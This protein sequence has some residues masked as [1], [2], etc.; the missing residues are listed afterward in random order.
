MNV[1]IKLHI[2]KY[3]PF[4]VAGAA[5]RTMTKEIHISRPIITHRT[6][7]TGRDDTLGRERDTGS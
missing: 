2:S 1:Y 3:V 4:K 5:I 6:H 7:M